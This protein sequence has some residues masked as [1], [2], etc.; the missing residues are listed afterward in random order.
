MTEGPSFKRG[1]EGHEILRMYR[2][3]KLPETSMIWALAQFPARDSWTGGD[4]PYGTLYH[5][6]TWGYKKGI[7]TAELHD[8]I[9]DVHDLMLSKGLIDA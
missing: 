6:L 5:I 4:Y 1:M 3:G 9:L 7:L 2:D 8:E